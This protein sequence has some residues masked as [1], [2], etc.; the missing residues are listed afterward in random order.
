VL[1][2]YDSFRPGDRCWNTEGAWYGI[3]TSDKAPLDPTEGY[4]LCDF[5]K[6]SVG[7]AGIDGYAGDG[8]KVLQPNQMDT[9]AEQV[10]VNT[11]A[12]FEKQGPVQDMWADATSLVPTGYPYM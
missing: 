3:P 12:E 8:A 7:M 1:Q 6:Y 9:D 5:G 2:D 10:I 11:F 4:G